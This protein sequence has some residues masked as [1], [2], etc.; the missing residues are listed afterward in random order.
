MTETKAGTLYGRRTDSGELVELPQ[1]YAAPDYVICRR[2]ADY[3]PSPVPPGAGRTVC[4]RC[5]AAIAFNPNGP[6]QDKPRRCMQCAGITP[7]PIE[8]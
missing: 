5:G 7:L 4:S 2:V 6:H 8:S 3:A 1:D